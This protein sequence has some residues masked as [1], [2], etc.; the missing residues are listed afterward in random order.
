[1]KHAGSS[2]E[3]PAMRSPR[4]LGSA[5]SS[6][7]AAS[8]AGTSVT[9]SPAPCP[10]IRMTLRIAGSW[11]RTSWNL[12]SWTSSSTKAITEPESSAT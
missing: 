1:M 12:A 9:Q 8:R 2:G 4:T 6:S 10:V 5:A 3:I 11:P 7:P